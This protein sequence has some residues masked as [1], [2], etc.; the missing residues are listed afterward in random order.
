MEGAP[1]S[2][3]RPPHQSKGPPFGIFYDI[4]FWPKIFLKAPLAPVYTNFEGERAPIKRDF[5]VKIFLKV[6]KTTFLTGFF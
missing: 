3:I 4:H 6:P 5:V 2:T 1:F